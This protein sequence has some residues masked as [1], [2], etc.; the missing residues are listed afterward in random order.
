VLIILKQLKNVPKAQRGNIYWKIMLG[1]L[2][3]VLVI[4]AVTGRIHWVGAMIG[5]LLPLLRQLMP[6]LIRFFPLL[7]RNNTAHAEA[8]PSSTN[9]DINTAYSILGLQAGA[10]KEE[11]IKAHR[12]MMQKVHPDRGGSD[13]LAAQ[14]NQAKDLLL[15]SFN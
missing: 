3:A 6:L 15:Q 10:S 14:I 2:G 7:Q 12:H 4:L 1:G 5:A 13:Y 8:P 9:I 11:I